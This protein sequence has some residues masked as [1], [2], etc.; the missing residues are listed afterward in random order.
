[1]FTI[2]RRQFLNRTAAGAAAAGALAAGALRARGSLTAVGADRLHRAGYVLMGLSM[3]L[4]IAIGLRGG[5][6]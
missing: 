4:F 3:A 5:P 1:M 6:A 2:S